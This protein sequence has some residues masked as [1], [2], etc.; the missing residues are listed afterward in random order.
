MLTCEYSVMWKVKHKGQ[1]SHYTH[2]CEQ[3]DLHNLGKQIHLSF[4]LHCSNAEPWR[5]FLQSQNPPIARKI[6]CRWMFQHVIE[7]QIYFLLPFENKLCSCF[8]TE[9]GETVKTKPDCCTNCSYGTFIAPCGILLF[10]S[11]SLNGTRAQD[12]NFI[13]LK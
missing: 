9:E 6:C 13:L 5:V 4:C 3:G 7:A 12:C 10:A 11:M 2:N 8:I 1:R